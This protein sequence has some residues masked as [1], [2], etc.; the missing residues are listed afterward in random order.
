[1]NHDG[2]GRNQLGSALY[3]V[4]NAQNVQ[5]TNFVSVGSTWIN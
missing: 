3:W 1:M 4:Q 5:I 2:M